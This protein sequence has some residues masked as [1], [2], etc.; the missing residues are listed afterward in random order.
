V[1]LVVCVFVLCGFVLGF[2]VGEVLNLV[3]WILVLLV[4]GVVVC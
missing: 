4:F 1:S 2:W 3:R